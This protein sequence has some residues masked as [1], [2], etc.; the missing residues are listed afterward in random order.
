MPADTASEIGG[1][2]RAQMGRQRISMAEL[3][4]R[5]GINRTT[6]AHRIDVGGVTAGNLVDIADALDIEPSDLL[7]PRT[8]RASA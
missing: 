4:R 6:L 2:I 3:A 8:V 7:P 1:N 5:T